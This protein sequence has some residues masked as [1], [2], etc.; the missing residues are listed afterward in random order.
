MKKVKLLALTL[1]CGFAI[2]CSCNKEEDSLDG[3]WDPMEW[4]PK[5]SVYDGVYYIQAKGDTVSF[6]CKNYS[7][8]WL[9]GAF[10]D[11]AYTNNDTD[12]S[13]IGEWF[14]ASFE[15]NKFTIIFAQNTSSERST[16]ITVTAGDIFDN[17]KFTQSGKDSATK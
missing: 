7:S 10:T 11:Y 3:D 16:E 1:I 4:E 8:P 14:S 13:I 5:H 12:T 17:F 15:G 9:C 6:V 2:L